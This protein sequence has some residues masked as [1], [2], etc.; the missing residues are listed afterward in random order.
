MGYVSDNIGLIRANNS[1][2]IYSVD[3]MENTVDAYANL[4]FPH[5]LDNGGN[6]QI[7]SLTID[8]LNKEDLIANTS[9]MVNKNW[10]EE[11]RLRNS[12][13]ET[14]AIWGFKEAFHDI[15][16]SRAIS[17]GFC[18]GGQKLSFYIS[19]QGHGTGQID[20]QWV[21]TKTSIAI[22]AI[23]IGNNTSNTLYTFDNFE[24]LDSDVSRY[25]EWTVPNIKSD[26]FTQYG[27]FGIVVLRIEVEQNYYED[28]QFEKPLMGSF[29][30]RNQASLQL[31]IYSGAKEIIEVNAGDLNILTATPSYG[32]SLEDIFADTIF[33]NI[34]SLNQNPLS[35][36]QKRAIMADQIAFL[37][38]SQHPV[39]NADFYPGKIIGGGGEEAI[40]PVKILKK[41]IT[42]S[43]R[44]P[45]II[46]LV[47]DRLFG[48]FAAYKAYDFSVDITKKFPDY[49]QSSQVTRDPVRAILIDDE[50]TVT[51]DLGINGLAFDPY[52]AEVVNAEF[53]FD[54][55]PPL[56][57]DVPLCNTL[58]DLS[59]IQITDIS[60]NPLLPLA[61]EVKVSFAVTYGSDKISEIRY[62]LFSKD[63]GNRKEYID[64]TG[65]STSHIFDLDSK[66][67]IVL[68]PLQNGDMVDVR[69][70]IKDISGITTSFYASTF[71]QGYTSKPAI[72]DLDTYQRN[73][74]SDVVDIYYTYDGLGEIN[75]SYLTVQYSLNEGSSWLTIPVVSLRG[76]FGNNLMSGRGR[77]TWVPNIDTTKLVSGQL[78]LFKLTLLD[79][80][81]L[82]NVGEPITGALIWDIE[83]PEVA[84]RRLSLEEQADMFISSSSSSGSSSSSSSIDSSSSS[85]S[86]SA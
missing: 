46:P 35:V 28:A 53:L 63:A 66:T 52:L 38:I 45:E 73:D 58:V 83:K 24:A 21:Y 12:L 56:V 37:F 11:D 86:S 27:L 15:K 41:A 5:V 26:L 43:K 2:T 78:I 75:S 29:P 34:S 18:F 85:S 30:S 67:A 80:D 31:L 33:D 14:K 4:F 40:Q 32:D 9:Q 84:V 65:I 72:V 48:M 22:K 17:N 76:D 47:K 71:V 39:V 20:N 6:S 61:T 49:L 57:I 55:P 3:V 19:P 36:D 59:N 13:I 69:I 81:G 64:S 42:Y 1:S 44:Y 79:A 54:T 8:V 23:D 74:G 7:I 25:F 50:N 16:K 77:I 82:A 70:D 10:V 62:V 60:G 51:G 68:H